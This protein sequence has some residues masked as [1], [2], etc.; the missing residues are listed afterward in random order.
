MVRTE[1][2]TIFYVF[3]NDIIIAVGQAFPWGIISEKVNHA[4]PIFLSITDKSWNYCYSPQI[5]LQP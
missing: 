3:R 1:V 4:M 5:N 2:Q